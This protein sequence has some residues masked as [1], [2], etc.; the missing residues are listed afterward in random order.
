M[1]WWPGAATATKAEVTTSAGTTG[2][3][4]PA[5]PTLPP[6]PAGA[7]C[8]AGYSQGSVGLELR[9]RSQPDLELGVQLQPELEREL[10]KVGAAVGGGWPAWPP[11]FARRRGSPPTARRVALTGDRAPEPKPSSVHAV[12]CD[13][14]IRMISSRPRKPQISRAALISIAAVGVVLLALPGAV[15][16]KALRPATRTIRYHGARL[17]VP[18]SWPVFHLSAGSHVCV[19]FNRHAVYLG[20]PGTSQYCPMQAAGRTEA[21][22]ISPASYRGGLLTPVSR[23]GAE[24]RAGSMARLTDHSDR[25]VITAT[26]N[27]DPSVVRRALGLQVAA[28]GSACHKR[29]RAQGREDSRH[30]VPRASTDNV[31]R[32]AG[33]PRGA[34]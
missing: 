8:T 4:V 29:S 11:P 2:I 33:A 10:V 9:C 16:A 20:R 15:V 27:R 12:V 30:R 23:L 13:V 1:A 21:I 31:A 28:R 3:S 32:R 22:L 17:E 19:R 14:V 18:A 24:T 7:R 6:C 25:L 26:W 34:V 5:A